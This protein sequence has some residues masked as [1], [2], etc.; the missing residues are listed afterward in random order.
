MRR[1]LIPSAGGYEKLTIA[2]APDPVAGPDEELVRVEA[3]GVN[4]AD[5][6]VRMG[7]Y[8]SAQQ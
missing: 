7:L 3:I 5:C 4:Y 1:I 2:E 6:I 8:A